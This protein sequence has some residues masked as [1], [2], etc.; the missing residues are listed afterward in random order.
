MGSR[1]MGWEVLIQ[2]EMERHAKFFSLGI[3]GDLLGLD[4]LILCPE[5][6]KISRMFS[7]FLHMVCFTLRIEISGI[8]IKDHKFLSGA[9]DKAHILLLTMMR[10]FDVA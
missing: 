3:C 4:S 5:F 6:K 1:P 2:L 10:S 8:F 9:L 7:A